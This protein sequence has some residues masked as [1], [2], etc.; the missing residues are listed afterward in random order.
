MEGQVIC[1]PECQKTVRPSLHLPQEMLN[2][3]NNRYLTEY[4]PEL[5][6]PYRQAC[7]GIPETMGHNARNGVKNGN[8]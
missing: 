4:L 7:E 1:P 5:R 3:Y 8:F 6:L 2:E